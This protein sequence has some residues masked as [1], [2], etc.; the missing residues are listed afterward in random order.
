MP[1]GMH[2]VVLEFPIG[3]IWD[4]VKEMDN[5]APLVPGYIQHEKINHHQSTWEFAG[6]MGIF[7]KK[8][9]L[10]IDIKEW[11]PPTKVSFELNGEKYSGEGYF[12]ALVINRNKTRLTGFL[13]VNANGKMEAMKNSFL[14]KAI[15][16]SAEEMALAITAKIE[17]LAL[18]N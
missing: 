2:Q 7:K 10:L 8:V 11:Q 13:E 12:E 18:K 17:E 4:F 1:S 3:V 9:N 15:P 6:D 16:K 5:W 14:K